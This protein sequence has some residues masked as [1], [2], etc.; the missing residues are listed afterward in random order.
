MLTPARAEVARHLE[1]YREWERR[2]LA[3]PDDPEVRAGFEGMGQ[4]L[5]TLMGK[6]CAREAAQAAERLLR[7]DVAP[8]PR[9]APVR[10]LPPVAGKPR[11]AT[12]PRRGKRASARHGDPARHGEPAPAGTP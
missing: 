10:T 1:R 9:T 11:A 6:R 4:T 12:G 3:A 2:M 8:T 5:C 7:A